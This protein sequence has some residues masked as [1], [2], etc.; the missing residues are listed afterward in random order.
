MKEI[1]TFVLMPFGAND[2]YSGGVIESE[3]V[4]SEI[5]EPG[6]KEAEKLFCSLPNNQTPQSAKCF[7]V[8][9]EVDKNRTGSIT[10]AIVRDI[11]KADVVIVDITG[12]NPNVFLE[13]GIRYALRNKVTVLLAQTGT[14]IPFDIKV[15]RYIEYD[16]FKPA[17]ARKRIAESILEGLSDSVTSDSAVFDVLPSLSVNIPGVAESFGEEASSG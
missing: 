9:R 10:A 7:K 14:L 3:Y 16:R 4:F 17:A 11:A 12:R 13:L 15:Y 6:V 5:I 1:S 8:R 2:E